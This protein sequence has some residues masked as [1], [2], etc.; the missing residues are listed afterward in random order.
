M[1]DNLAAYVDD[2]DYK[3]GNTYTDHF[4]NEYDLKTPGKFVASV[5]GVLGSRFIISLDYEL[6]DYGKTRLMVPA[7]SSDSHTWY[8]AHN[9][10]ISDD[11][12]L[13]STVR[14]G[15]EYRVTSQLYGRLGYA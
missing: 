12:L 11:Y 8:D 5:A 1:V 3:P 9:Q 6:M 10:F 4:T 2:P 13:A 7:N 14:F 15:M